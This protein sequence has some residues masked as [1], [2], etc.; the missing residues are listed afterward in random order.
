MLPR[1]WRSIGSLLTKENC[2]SIM[3]MVCI[4]EINFKYITN[5]RV[6]WRIEKYQQVSSPSYLKGKVFTGNW[7]FCSAPPYMLFASIKKQNVSFSKGLLFGNYHVC[8]KLSFCKD[9]Q[10]Y[11]TNLVFSYLQVLPIRWKLDFCISYSEN[12]STRQRRCFVKLSTARTIS[13]LANFQ[14][15]SSTEAKIRTS[16]V[17]TRL[18]SHLMF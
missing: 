6:F 14:N 11:S 17:N 13:N 8:F 9:W 12:Y 1:Q 2:V 4:V 16:L 10:C 18:D 3:E 7:I 15:Y 5:G